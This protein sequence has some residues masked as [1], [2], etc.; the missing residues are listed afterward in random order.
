MGLQLSPVIA[1]GGGG[2]VSPS[3]I[4]WELELGYIV[5]KDRDINMALGGQTSAGG[6]FGILG[7]ASLH[8]AFF[9][10]SSNNYDVI[11]GDP[12][13]GVQ[14]TL[15][16]LGNIHP[17]ANINFEDDLTGDHEIVGGENGEGTFTINAGNAGTNDAAGNDLLIKSGN[18][19]SGGVGD[20]PSGHIYIRPG[21]YAGASNHGNIYIQFNDTTNFVVFNTLTTEVDFYQNVNIGDSSVVSNYTLKFRGTGGSA[22]YTWNNADVRMELDAKMKFGDTISIYGNPSQQHA[23]YAYKT[24]LNIAD[25]YYIFD[26]RV[27]KTG[28]ITNVNDT[29][30]G[31]NAV[32]TINDMGRT[33]GEL[34]GGTIKAELDSGD[35]GQ[36]DIHKEMGGIYSSAEVGHGTVYGDLYGAKFNTVVS[37]NGTVSDDVYGIYSSVSNL[38][39]VSGTVYMIYLDEIAGVDYGIY[40]NGTS[41]NVLGGNLFIETIKSGA[42]QVAAGAAANELWKTASHASLPDNVVMIGV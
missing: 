19:G 38:G 9:I 26:G 8:F 37:S 15:T 5:P 6:S 30:T 12:N 25:S 41:P 3:D 22:T 23:V 14:P 21:L 10:D 16:T 39:A 40:Q 2:G 27:I 13:L 35:V 42:T 11:I 28:G 20:N 36:S 17:R 7:D 29:F 24:D 34:Y 18:G 33:H 32:M 31:I 4:L 1:G